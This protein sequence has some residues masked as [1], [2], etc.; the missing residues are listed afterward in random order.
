ML[1]S[2]PRFSEE[3]YAEENILRART[4]QVAGEGGDG[5]DGVAKRPKLGPPVQKAWANKW[6]KKL[7]L[8]GVR[9][10]FE[11]HAPFASC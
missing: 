7:K 6:R 11:A 10:P 1:L 3:A 2:H 9:E 4:K 8:A 5:K